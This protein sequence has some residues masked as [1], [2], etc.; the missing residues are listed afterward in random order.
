MEG[1]GENGGEEAE[2]SD[3][4]VK[5]A[6][7]PS[8]NPDQEVIVEGLKS[9]CNILLHNE[10]GQVCGQ[11]TVIYCTQPMKSKKTIIIIGECMDG[12]CCVLQ[13]MAGD[14]QLIKGV[15]ERLKQCR[16]PTWNHEVR[17][18]LNKNTNA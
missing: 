18:K 3:D 7:P 4:V 1:E 11:N 12:Y 17:Q 5:E 14:L 15:A 6:S 13:V 9:I 2:A 16:D 8:E 10:T